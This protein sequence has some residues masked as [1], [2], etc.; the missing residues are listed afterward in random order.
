M[1]CV[2]GEVGFSLQDLMNYLT[3]VSSI[4]S[5]LMAYPI[6]KGIY[7]LYKRTNEINENKDSLEFYS[8]KAEKSYPHRVQIGFYLLKKGSYYS[9]ATIF[10]LMLGGGFI[11]TSFVMKGSKYEQI[12]ILPLIFGFLCVLFSLKNMNSFLHTDYIFREIWDKHLDFN[13][14]EGKNK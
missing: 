5:I 11:A 2:E 13:E 9:F 12:S 8:K 3:P 4:C 6:L 14:T 10:F 1:F 7:N